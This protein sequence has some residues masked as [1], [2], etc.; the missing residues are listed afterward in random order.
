LQSARQYTAC[1]APGNAAGT[2]ASTGLP[3]ATLLTSEG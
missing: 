2:A 3:A 1:D